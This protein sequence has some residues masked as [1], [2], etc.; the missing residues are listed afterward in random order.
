MSLSLIS[1][2]KGPVFIGSVLGLFDGYT[3]FCMPAAASVTYLLG[4][5]LGGSGYLLTSNIPS[6][7]IPK[8]ILT[9]SF[10]VAHSVV[11]PSYC[12]GVLVGGCI[13]YIENKN[14]PENRPKYYSRIDM[15]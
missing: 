11:L 3:T 4:A 5:S 1:K 15:L 14:N 9:N 2:I 10:I 13:N 8:T 7:L 6:H 12:V